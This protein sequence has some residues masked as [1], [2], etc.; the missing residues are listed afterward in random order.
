MGRRHD[1]PAGVLKTGRDASVLIYGDAATY[2]IPTV[3]LAGDLD[4]LRCLLP[5]DA[6]RLAAALTR[7][8]KMARGEHVPIAL[9]E[10]LARRGALR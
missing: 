4:Q 2:G 7:A 6:D 1:V 8:A 10:F 3:E 5:E 9:D